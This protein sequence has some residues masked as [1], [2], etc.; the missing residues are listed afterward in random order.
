MTGD[1]H[2]VMNESWELHP[3]LDLP[4]QFP[5]AVMFTIR[6]ADVR[7]E[8]EKALQKL[9]GQQGQLKVDPL[10]W[11]VPEM[12]RQATLRLAWDSMFKDVPGDKVGLLFRNEGRQG[13]EDGEEEGDAVYMVLIKSNA[14]DGRKWIVTRA[15]E[16]EGRVV[17]WCVPFEVRKGERT[18]V[19]LTGENMLTLEMP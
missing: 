15:S 3:V 17:C 10:P 16:F 4:D 7:S 2:D 5:P 18:E 14:P 6:D 11:E 19:E 12:L 8:Y 13:H 1:T 9:I